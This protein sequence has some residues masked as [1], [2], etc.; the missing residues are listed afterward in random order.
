VRSAFLQRVQI[1]AAEREQPPEQRRCGL[2]PTRAQSLAFSD[3]QPTAP[4]QVERAGLRGLLRW[5]LWRVVDTLEAGVLQP[6][7]PSSQSVL[8][9]QC[10]QLGHVYK[11]MKERMGLSLALIILHGELRLLRHRGSSVGEQLLFA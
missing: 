10:A 6:A 9:W 4:E 2:S 5:T 7:G 1:A 11:A 3:A 8:L